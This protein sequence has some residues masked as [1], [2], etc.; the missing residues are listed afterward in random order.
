ME[1]ETESKVKTCGGFFACQGCS[2]FLLLLFSPIQACNA[3]SIGRPAYILK[4]G[5]GHT[6]EHLLR[7]G[8]L[9]HGS[10]E[11]FI[12][13]VHAGDQRPNTRQY[14]AEIKTIELTQH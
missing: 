6:F 2:P 10:R 8:E 4:T 7:C 11:I 9:L 12:R 14:I 1:R 5:H 3:K 13:A